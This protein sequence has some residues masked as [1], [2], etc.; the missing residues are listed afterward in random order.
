VFLPEKAK[1]ADDEKEQDKPLDV[2]LGWLE[3]IGEGAW[4]LMWVLLIIN[5]I[6]QVRLALG[7]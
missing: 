4:K 5:V 2:G 3:R 1:Q 7:W 6:N